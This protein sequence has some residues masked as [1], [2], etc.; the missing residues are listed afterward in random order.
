MLPPKNTPNLLLPSRRNYMQA[1]A[2]ALASLS[3]PCFAKMSDFWSQPRVL[4]LYRPDT[5]EVVKEVYWANGALVMPGYLRICQLLRDIHVNRAV[6]FDIVTLDIVRGVYGW[7]QS[8]GINQ[9]I[10]VNSGYR[11]PS[12]N[13]N[14][15]GVRNSL[16]TMAR[17]I[18]IRI[19]GVSTESIA[20][21]GM[22]LSGG[23]VGFYPGKQFTHLDRGRIR[24]WRG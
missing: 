13:A 5:R 16:H 21:F 24:Y 14:E 10:I 23:G 3:L 19:H 6:Q 20:R 1:A 2:G 7:L 11:H 17:A 15:G 22:Y 8:F 18:D 9:P 4:W 12:T